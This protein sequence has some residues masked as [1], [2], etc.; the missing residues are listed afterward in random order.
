MN[1]C[2]AA[3]FLGLNACEGQAPLSAVEHT[4]VKHMAEQGLSYGTKEEYEF[5]F[6]IF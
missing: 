4:F 2:T 6:N 1:F 5:R 3:A